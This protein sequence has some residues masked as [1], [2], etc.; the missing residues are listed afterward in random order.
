MERNEDRANVTMTISGACSGNPGPGGYA[1]LLRFGKQKKEIYG[2][3]PRTTN[4]GMEVTAL[5]KAVE[6]LKKP[7]TITVR[8]NCQFVIRCIA[9]AKEYAEND[10]TKKTGAKVAHYDIWKQLEKI[11]ADSN[12]KIYYSKIDLDDEDRQECARIAKEQI[13]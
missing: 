10:W 9:N 13:A 12:H 3:N 1:A 8:T 2:G 11:K 6:M 7:C 4:N 5:L